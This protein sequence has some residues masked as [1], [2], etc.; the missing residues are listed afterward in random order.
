RRS[1]GQIDAVDFMT[2]DVQEDSDHP[3]IQ[4]EGLQYGGKRFNALCKLADKQYGDKFNTDVAFERP[5]FGK[6]E[7]IAAHDSLAFAGISPPV[8]LVYPVETHIAEKLHA[9]T[10]PRARPNA[11][12]KDL[13]DLALLGQLGRIN[14]ER[15]KTA[16]DKT[17]EHR[18]THLVPRQLPA[19]PQDWERPY[20]QLQMDNDF[21][22]KTITVTYEAARK[23]LDPLLDETAVGCTWDPESWSWVN[24]T[25]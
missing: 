12:V 7:L 20:T 9:Y 15:L 18:Y 13:P 17:F 3:D 16:I 8:I 23:F 2:F 6:P 21:P 4:N 10:M 1:A 22:W 24:A 11:R 5:V 14:S 19:P 25:M